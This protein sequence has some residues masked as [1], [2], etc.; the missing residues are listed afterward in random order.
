VLHDQIF[1]QSLQELNITLVA[2]SSGLPVKELDALKI[3]L[4][5]KVRFLPDQH[6]LKPN[7][8]TNATAEQTA[9][10]II[11]AMESGGII[12]AMRGGYGARRLVSILSKRCIKPSTVVLIGYSDVTALHL[13]FSARAQNVCCIHASVARELIQ[14]GY[15]CDGFRLLM[16]ILSGQV[17]QVKIGLRPLNANAQK[18]LKLCGPLT[19]GNLTLVEASIGTV[20]QANC[21][22]KILLLEDIDCNLGQVTGSLAH[23][24][25]SGLLGGVKAIIFGRFSKGDDHEFIPILTEFA[26]RVNFPVFLTDKIGHGYYNYPIGYGAPGS[27]EQDAEEADSFTLCVDFSKIPLFKKN[28]HARNRNRRSAKR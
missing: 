2:P 7:P 23:L 17:K 21:K 19:G 28:H 10:E 27:I 15:D 6:Y 18:T 12:W 3:L 1:L 11:Q 9:N 16:G 25:D 8:W 14:K 24:E 20:W 22:D 4:D 26:E 13:L 5:G